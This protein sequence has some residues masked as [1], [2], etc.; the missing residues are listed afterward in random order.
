MEDFSLRI[1]AIANQLRGLGDKIIDKDV[2]KK[3]LYSIPDHLEQ[4]VILIETLLG[5]NS[6]SAEEATDHLRVVEERKKK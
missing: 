2:I 6:M 4:V 1:S 3:I 5:L